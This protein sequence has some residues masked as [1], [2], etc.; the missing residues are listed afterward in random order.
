VTK[1]ERRRERERGKAEKR[2]YFVTEGASRF[3]FIE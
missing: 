2:V 3:V 1:E